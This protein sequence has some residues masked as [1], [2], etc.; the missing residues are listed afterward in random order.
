VSPFERIRGDHCF[1]VLNQICGGKRNFKNPITMKFQNSCNYFV[2]T[3]LTNI[4][5]LSRWKEF[6]V[7]TENLKKWNLEDQCKGSQRNISGWLK[8]A[9][10]QTQGWGTQQIA[11]SYFPFQ[12][13]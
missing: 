6:G 7:R 8:A 11:S 4:L 12:E 3:Q 10:V 9:D 13:E 2:P 5:T 1:V